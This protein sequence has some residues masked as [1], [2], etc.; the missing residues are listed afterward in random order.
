LDDDSGKQFQKRPKR[1]T[2]NIQLR[3]TTEQVTSIKTKLKEKCP[4]LVETPD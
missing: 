4:M 2:M 1:D 3:P